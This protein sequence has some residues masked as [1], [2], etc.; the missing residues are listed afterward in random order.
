[1]KIGDRISPT[2]E[3]VNEFNERK[4]IY[5][6]ILEKALSDIYTE[7]EEMDINTDFIDISIRLFN[8]DFTEVFEVS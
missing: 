5:K 6:K 8:H 4:E 1:M 7:L 2:Q 3:T